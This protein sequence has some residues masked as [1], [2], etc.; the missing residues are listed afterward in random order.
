MSILVSY[1]LVK[2]NTKNAMLKNFLTIAI[3]NLLKR[4]LFSFINIF[5]LAVGV[6][7]CLVILNYIDFETSY[8]SF[9]ANAGTLYRINRT[10]EMNGEKKSPIVVTTYGL[11]PALAADLPEVRRY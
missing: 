2:L 9:N 8:D 7:T 10:Y 1:L 11:G 5:G 3:R 4:K 6:C